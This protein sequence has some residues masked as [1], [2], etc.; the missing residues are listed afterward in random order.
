MQYEY[1]LTRH[2]FRDVAVVSTVGGLLAVYGRGLTSR[3]EEPVLATV[4]NRQ[5]DGVIFIKLN[6]VSNILYTIFNFRKVSTI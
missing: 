5:L 3:P 2:A 6:T 4:R 1:E